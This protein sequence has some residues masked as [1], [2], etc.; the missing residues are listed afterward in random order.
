M[1][2]S[3]T[4]GTGGNRH[5]RN[6]VIKLPL[7]PGCLP[8]FGMRSPLPCGL[9]REY[10]GFYKTA[11][12]GYLDERRLYLHHGAD[13]PTSSTLRTPAVDGA[14]EEVCASHP[15]VAECAVNRIADPLKGRCRRA[16]WSST[17]MFPVKQKKSRRRSSV[18]CASASGPV[19]AFRNGVCVKRLPK[20]RS[21]KILR[22]TI[23]KIHRPPAL[24]DAGD[25]RRSGDP[26]RALPN[27]A[28]KGDWRLEHFQES[29]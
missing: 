3:T 14:M 10:P 22:S 24:D 28:V 21:G 11:D 19:A 18:S 5:A 17:P 12:A 27:C 15:D 23:Q 4:R 25:D 2:S 29:V 9:S 6:V 20:T 8:D 16:S 26:R 7:P 1:Q 13:R